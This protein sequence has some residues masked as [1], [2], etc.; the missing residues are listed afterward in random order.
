MAGGEG[1]GEEGNECLGH[2]GQA[3]LGYLLVVHFDVL[4]AQ[5]LHKDVLVLL[6]LGVQGLRRGPA[7]G[8]VGGGVLGS[9][10]TPGCCRLG[11]AD[12]LMGRGETVVLA[13]VGLEVGEDVIAGGARLKALGSGGCT[14]GAAPLRVLLGLALAHVHAE[15]GEGGLPMGAAGGGAVVPPCATVGGWRGTGRG[16]WC[17][18]VGSGHD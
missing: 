6:H 5:V 9:G 15:L 11:G 7:V 16:R 3:T 17:R 14:V 18:G 13:L 2:C 10:A 1:V 12:Q 8:V 4:V